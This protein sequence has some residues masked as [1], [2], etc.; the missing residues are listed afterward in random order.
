MLTQ[1][2]IFRKAASDWWYKQGA[3][4]LSTPGRWFVWTIMTTITVLILAGLTVYV[5]DPFQV[6]RKPILGQP[7]FTDAY[8]T[9]PGLIRHYNYDS[10]V[11]GS[12][13]CQNFRISDI[14]NL[15][16]WNCIKLT[17]SG[18]RPATVRLLVSM[19][20]ARKPVKHVL[21][22]VDILNFG[23]K[24]TEHRVIL[25]DY[26]Y[27]DN[28]WNDYRYL[29]NKT[30]LF[31]NIPD[32]LKANLRHKAKYR[33]KLDIDRMWA[34]DFGDGRYRY[35]RD[36]VMGEE[37]AMAW[38]RPAP[39]DA[40]ASDRMRESLEINFLSIIRANRGTEFVLFFPPYSILAWFIARESGNL[41]SYLEFKHWSI[42]LLQREPNV[43]LY[44]FQGERDI[45]CNF[46]NYKDS[47][48]YS[49]A[50]NR[51]ILERIARDQN[52]ITREDSTGAV[53]IIRS[54][55]AE[56]SAAKA[57]TSGKPLGDIPDQHR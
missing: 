4:F 14:R 41:D 53:D 45:M 12:S 51:L 47:T 52:R 19:A 49:P 18:C 33:Q 30:I 7:V 46:D 50:I 17:P 35:G 28:P 25:P 43:K 48:H 37:Q 13:M 44:D 3:R 57:A 11:V 5:I 29:W 1:I 9:M 55:V 34:W 15:L 20:C 22:G 23:G 8:S 16:G 39:L 21:L 24:A 2:R 54:A 27:D 32:V 10:L 40:A 56:F 36:A 31:S 38:A 42:P 6:Y 26:L